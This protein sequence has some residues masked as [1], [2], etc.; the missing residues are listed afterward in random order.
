MAMVKVIVGATVF[1]GL[2]IAADFSLEVGS[3]AAVQPV[4]GSAGVKKIAAVAVRVH[5]CEA[6]KLQPLT[7]S[8]LQIVNGSRLTA[9]LRFVAGIQTGTFVVGR[10]DGRMSNGSVLAITGRCG[11]SEAGVVVALDQN[12]LIVRETVRTMSHAPTDADTEAVLNAS[13]GGPK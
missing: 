13:L 9:P 2:G 5:N 11:S 3:S 6:G 1:A 12:G 10:E 7:G 4:T 8:S